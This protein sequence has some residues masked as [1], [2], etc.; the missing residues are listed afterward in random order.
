MGGP[1][2]KF[3]IKSDKQQKTKHPKRG[4]TDHAKRRRNRTRRPRW[5]K[6]RWRWWRERQ[7]RQRSRTGRK[8][9]LPRLR[10]KGAPPD[11]NS[12]LRPA[13]SQVWSIHGTGIGLVWSPLEHFFKKPSEELMRGSLLLAHFLIRRVSIPPNS[14]QN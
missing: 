14:G 6:K 7:R 3:L 1:G 13:V 11:G 5:A 9:R 2:W 8:L 12:L 10:R 4:G